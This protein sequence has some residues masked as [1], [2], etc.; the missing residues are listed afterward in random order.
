MEMENRWIH[1]KLK[2]SIG[3][4]RYLH[5]VRV[6]ETCID[7]AK[8][9]GYPIERVAIAGLLHDCGRLLDKKKILK[10]IKDFDIILDNMVK[11]NEELIHA[12]L[13]EEL[14][15]REYGIE[16]EEILN[17]IRYHTTGREDMG[18][19]EKI[20]YIADVIEPNRNFPGVEDIRNMAY[21]DIDKSILH[22]MESTIRFLIDKGSLIHLDTIKGRNQLLKL[23]R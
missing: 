18:L 19:I 7:L 1:G 15:R 14:A 10:L 20:V 5:S 16:D 23:K 22:S 6:M 11:N 12:L 8:H 3:Y 4:D 9:H 17:A 2:D 21:K 13:G